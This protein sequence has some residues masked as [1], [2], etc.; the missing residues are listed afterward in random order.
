MDAGEY[1]LVALP[2]TH[3]DRRIGT[4]VAAVSLAPYEEAQHTA[5]IASIALSV[6]VLMVVA[7]V[8]RWILVAV[9]RPVSSMTVS[10]RDWSEHDLD[11]RFQ[12]GAAHD[13]LTELAATLD[14]LL[15]RNATALRREQRLTAEIS[16]ELRTPL[17]RITTQSELALRRE[18]PAEEYRTALGAIGRNAASMTGIIDTLLA[19]SRAAAGSQPESA[20]A[21]EAATRAADAAADV[22]QANDVELVVDAVRRDAV[23]A[24]DVELATRILHPLVDNACRYGVTRATITIDCDGRDVVFMIED[25]GSGVEAGELDRIFLPGVRGSRAAAT[26]GAG[27]G[28][29]LARRLVE[30]VN[31]TIEVVPGST[32]DFVVRIPSAI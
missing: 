15:D 6:I 22:A 25:D 1:R 18:R 23:V 5:V 2:V 29:A 24:T 21:T 10:A 4:V 16:H 26:T 27:L 28:L 12:L 3:S 32:G 20:S 13:E 31:G 30:S 17:A 9:L 11:R 7:F 14:Q 19:A 8:T